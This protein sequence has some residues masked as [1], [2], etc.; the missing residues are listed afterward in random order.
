MF[1]NIDSSVKEKVCIESEGGERER[2][3]KLREQ[4]EDEMTS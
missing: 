4:F 3:R 1:W 2:K